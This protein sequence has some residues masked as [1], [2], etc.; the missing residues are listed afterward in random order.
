M[1][2][3]KAHGIIIRKTRCIVGPD[4][5]IYVRQSNLLGDGK[6]GV[7]RVVARAAAAAEGCS[8]GLAARAAAAGAAGG[9]VA[10]GAGGARGGREGAAAAAG[11]VAGAAAGAAGGGVAAAG[12]VAGRAAAMVAGSVAAKEVVGM[13]VAAR[14]AA[15]VAVRAAARVAVRPPHGSFLAAEPPTAAVPPRDNACAV[16][17]GIVKRSAPLAC[18][19]GHEFSCAASA[20]SSQCVGRARTYERLLR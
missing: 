3:F 7:A 1:I 5:G 13:A 6:G 16:S 20:S 9:G 15:R 2:G 17:C 8:K 4:C 18:M 14:V 19:D 12:V 10:V 11:A